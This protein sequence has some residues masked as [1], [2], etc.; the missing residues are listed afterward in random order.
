[1]K[2]FKVSQESKLVTLVKRLPRS[3]SAPSQDLVNIRV[4]N[5]F[6]PHGRASEDWE[7]IWTLTLPTVPFHWLSTTG[8]RLGQSNAGMLFNGETLDEVVDKATEF[9][10]W[11]DQANHAPNDG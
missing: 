5:D 6:E 7:I 4:G 8:W 3:Y 10:D 11:Y 1:M 9:M 2:T